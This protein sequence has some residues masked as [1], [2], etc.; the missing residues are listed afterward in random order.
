M[1]KISNFDVLLCI[2]ILLFLILLWICCLFL[3]S[4][5]FS[6]IRLLG[7]STEG[8]KNCFIRLG[9]LRLSSR[10]L[11]CNILILL[12][13]ILILSAHHYYIRFHCSWSSSRFYLMNQIWLCRFFLPHPRL[14]SLPPLCKRQKC[15]NLLFSCFPDLFSALPMLRLYPILKCSN[16]RWIDKSNNSLSYVISPT[17]TLLFQLLLI[18]KQLLDFLFLWKY[19]EK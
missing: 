4:C 1:T 3:I 15:Y 12:G 8:V 5:D 6:N 11:L 7:M 13:Y 14:W 18:D 19:A 2:V 16:F 17:Q 10:S 9:S